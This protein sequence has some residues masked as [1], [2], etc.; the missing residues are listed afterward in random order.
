MSPPPERLRAWTRNTFINQCSPAVLV[1]QPHG[2]AVL[3]AGRA[4]RGRAV[5]DEVRRRSADA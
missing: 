1:R 5:R 2:R 3:G 4:R